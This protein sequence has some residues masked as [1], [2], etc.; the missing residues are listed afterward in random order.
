AAEQPPGPAAGSRRRPRS[1]SA[2]HARRCAR[3]CGTARGAQR[4]CARCAWAASRARL[5][6]RLVY[7]DAAGEVVPSQGRRQGAALAQNVFPMELTQ[8]TQ[9][10]SGRDEHRGGR[11]FLLFCLFVID[12]PGSPAGSLDGQR[13]T[14]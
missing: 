10:P 5:L 12:W 11:L 6:P 2:E 13:A 4:S 7:V 8:V 1:S 9:T 3:E 14:R